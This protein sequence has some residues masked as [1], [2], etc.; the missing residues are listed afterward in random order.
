M[1]PLRFASGIQLQLSV[2]IMPIF[3]I[4]IPNV[5]R[6]LQTDIENITSLSRDEINACDIIKRT[7]KG[8]LCRLNF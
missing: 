6:H 2:I 5:M 8:Q 1:C 7:V 4:R 3:F